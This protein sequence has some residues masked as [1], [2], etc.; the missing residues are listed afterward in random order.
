MERSIQGSTLPSRPKKCGGV[1]VQRDGKVA[2]VGNFTSVDTVARNKVARIENETATSQLTVTGL[3]S[4][5]WLRDGASPE[6]Y[7]V[8][9]ESSTDGGITYTDLGDGVRFLGGWQ[10]AGLSI[11]A[12]ALVRAR[13]YV[14]GAY[15]NGSVGIVEDV[16][17][18]GPEDTWSWYYTTAL[19]QYNLFAS[20]GQYSFA[21][22][23][24]HYFHGQGNYYYYL[25]H[26]DTATALLT[27]YS[28]LA[29]YYYNLY[30]Q[31]G[32]S[33]AGS[34]YF[35]AYLAI[36]YHAYYNEL[37][38]FNLANYYYGVYMAAA[39]AS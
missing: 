5:E 32:N 28:G 33:S 22:A 7:H 25:A 3:Q 34:F 15:L 37:G 16:I 36:A 8:T 24:Y 35:Y 4:I 19:N 30:A 21:S 23:F 26:G 29:N 12:D 27:Y 2:I 31:S 6:G 10:L 39:F 14:R 18:A 17:E 13:A 38:D 1:I 20:V 9:F 11:P